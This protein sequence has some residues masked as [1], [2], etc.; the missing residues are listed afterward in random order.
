MFTEAR[1]HLPHLSLLRLRVPN[2][3]L[4][5]GEHFFSALEA[6]LRAGRPLSG[7]AV[8]P[9]TSAA[10]AQTGAAAAEHGKAAAAE[11]GVAAEH[12]GA[13][14]SR[15]EFESLVEQELRTFSYSRPHHALDFRIACSCAPTLPLPYISEI[16]EN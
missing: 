9:A 12:G 3:S 2:T 16:C 7:S 4:Q 6:R 13:A 10:P 11:D 1:Y 5:M 14:L 15:A 8:A